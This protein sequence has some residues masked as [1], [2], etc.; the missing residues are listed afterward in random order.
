MAAPT[1]R[2]SLVTDIR[3]DGRAR[4]SSRKA[5]PEHV[6]HKFSLLL[7]VIA[8]AGGLA[9][10]AM[11]LPR[12][13]AAIAVIQAQPVA[14]S[15]VAGERGLF[16]GEIETAAE[17]L[18][19]A[20]SLA[21]DADS[22]LILADLR[23]VQAR[24]NTD[25]KIIDQRAQQSIDAA[26]I[27]VRNAP[28]HPAAW[29]ALAEAIDVLSRGGEAVVPPLMRALEVAPYDP[30]RRE[31]RIWLA[32]RHW[33]SLTPQAQQAAGPQIIAMARTN[34]NALA[35]LAKQYLGLGAVRAALA[36]DPALAQR[37]DAVYVALP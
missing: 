27:A 17:R 30:R 12:L 7:G 36:L 13:L 18:E 29:A 20:L 24:R 35:K 6:R 37:F 9:L 10:G 26:K 22:A 25:E 15:F 21:P 28:A 31:V 1:N 8:V 19:F 16:P 5:G 2:I 11:A 23:L 34:I 32:L 33:Q 14:E 4:R 3:P